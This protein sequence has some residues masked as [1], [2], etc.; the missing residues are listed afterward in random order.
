MK[1]NSMQNKAKENTG[2]QQRGFTLIEIMIVV[3]IIGLLAAIA[4]PNYTRARK[5]TFQKTCLQN[6]RQ[7]DGAVASYALE[8]R[9]DAGQPVNYDDI[10]AY[11]DKSV[12]CPAGG[13]SFE[14]SYAIAN[15]DSPTTCLRVVS[16]EFAHHR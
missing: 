14:D 2:H 8:A 3:A 5:V 11:L 10:K 7:I 16:G 12:F 4:I 6:L 1:G 15:I 13:T 9:K